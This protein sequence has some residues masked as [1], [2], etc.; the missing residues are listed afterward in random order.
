MSKDNPLPFSIPQGDLDVLAIGETLIDFISIE[1]SDSLK[2]ASTFRRHLGGSPAN[3]AVNISKLGGKAAVF[4]KVG[5]GAFGQFLQEELRSLGVITDYLIMDPTVHTTLIFVSHTPG[6]P[7]FEAYRNADYKLIAAEIND[8]AIK[9]ARVVHASTFSLSREPC[10][11][12]VSRALETA[13]AMGKIVSF[14]PNYSPRIWPDLEEAKRAISSIYRFTTVT[15]PS[16]DD[17]R[18]LLGEDFQPEQYIRMFHEMGPRLV[19]FTM[20]KDGFIISLDG[21]IMEH[22]KARPIK[23]VDATGAG[24]SFWAGFLTALLDGNSLHECG[25]FGREIVE[26]KL[27][28]IGQLPAN[29]DRYSIYN[30]LHI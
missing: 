5:A 22:I 19:V 9:R 25:L 15:K 1:M 23:A 3:I 24:D 7:D 11:S 16:L 18:R 26:L 17:A 27:T 20:G 30:K 12:A 6:T 13:F 8:E 21:Q 28:T 29:L 2:G 4:S 14:D 10:R